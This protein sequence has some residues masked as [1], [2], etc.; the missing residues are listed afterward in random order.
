MVIEA[1]SITKAAPL[2]AKLATT[3]AAPLKGAAVR[4]KEQLEVKFR[5]GFS[6]FIEEN[7]V[8]FS[9]VKTIISSNTPIPFSTLYV[10]LYLKHSNGTARDEDL[11]TNI[12][13]QRNVIFTATAGSGKSMLMR[14][15]YLRFLETQIER[16]PIF[17]E[18]RELNEHPNISLHEYVY[19]KIS[20][21]IDGF[22]EYQL[23]YAL[24]SGQIILFLDGFDEVDY[25]R[26]KD[27]ELQINELASRFKNLWMFVSS[28]PAETFAS[29]QKFYVYAVNP[30]SEKTSR[31]PNQ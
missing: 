9:T 6:R 29:W 15:L 21:Y 27:R 24:E 16:L 25:D 1:S 22:S 11:L 3:F 20:A 17:I 28:R 8:R 31:T 12:E 18:L 19:S 4:A 26:R 5:K 30:L 7:L 13:A 2:I 14:Y 23:K 10:N